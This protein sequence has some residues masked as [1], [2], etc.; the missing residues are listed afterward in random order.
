MWYVKKKIL[1]PW[2]LLC[3]RYPHMRTCVF[4]ELHHHQV[5]VHGCKLPFAD[6][7]CSCLLMTACLRWDVLNCANTASEV[8]TTQHSFDTPKAICI[9][10]LLLSPSHT[11]IPT[12]TYEYS[13]MCAFFFPA[14]I[15][16]TW[17][18]HDTTQIP[19]SELSA[20]KKW[21]ASQYRSAIISSQHFDIVFS[22]HQQLTSARTTCESVPRIQQLWWGM[23]WQWPDN[24]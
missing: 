5:K 4:W 9:P 1:T 2:Y 13:F 10:I 3:K 21:L 16:I 22:F 8:N 18:R 6:S 24:A 12:Y 23:T 20:A 15:P 19:S 7:G 14:S 11:N 17:L